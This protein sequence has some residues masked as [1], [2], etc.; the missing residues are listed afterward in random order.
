[1]SKARHYSC[2]ITNPAKE[3]KYAFLL[4]SFAISDAELSLPLWHGPVEITQ[5]M[6]RSVQ[7]YYARLNP[8]LALVE[9]DF[10]TSAIEHLRRAKVPEAS[11]VAPLNS[12]VEALVVKLIERERLAGWYREQ[13]KPDDTPHRHKPFDG[14]NVDRELCVRVIGT[15]LI[16]QPGCGHE[17]TA[18]YLNEGLPP[19]TQ[20]LTRHHVLR[21]F[22]TLRKVW[23]RSSHRSGLLYIWA[24]CNL[25]NALDIVYEHARGHPVFRKYRGEELAWAIHEDFDLNERIHRAFKLVR[26]NRFAAV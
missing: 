21:G 16:S 17:A 19:G 1:M 10:R 14:Q 25:L 6:P 12:E 5:D 11:L 22:E 24:D 2:R 18:K 20:G 4:T 3:S 26:A 8:T 7:A 13:I 23:R 9:G 15:A